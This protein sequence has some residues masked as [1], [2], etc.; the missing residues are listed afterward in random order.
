[1]SQLTVLSSLGHRQNLAAHQNVCPSPFD[2]LQSGQVLTG[3]LVES[4]GMGSRGI[5]GEESDV[6]GTQSREGEPI[7]D[8]HIFTSP[9][10]PLLWMQIALLSL[11]KETRH[12]LRRL[13]G[14]ITLQLSPRLHSTHPY[15]NKTSSICHSW[16][17]LFSPFRS[18]LCLEALSSV[19]TLM[20]WGL[21]ACGLVT[22]A[23]YCPV[24]T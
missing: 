11:C 14:D 22:V 20:C 5:Q 1:M 15:K 12:R 8:R 13:R 6:T 19:L 17:T 18:G 23:V 3:V 4:R 10:Q 9:S 2:T 24:P 16:Y 7:R 21:E